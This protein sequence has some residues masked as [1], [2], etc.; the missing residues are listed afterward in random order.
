M[1]TF[2]NSEISSLISLRIKRTFLQKVRRLELRENVLLL[3]P[4][5]YQEHLFFVKKGIIRCALIRFCLDCQTTVFENEPTTTGWNPWGFNTS[6]PLGSG[7]TLGG[8]NS[9]SGGSNYTPQCNSSI[10]SGTS[11]SSNQLPPCIPITKIPDFNPDNIVYSNFEDFANDPYYQPFFEDLTEAEIQ[12]FRDHVNLIWSGARNYNEVINFGI[13]RFHNSHEDN[14]NA[15]AYRHMLWCGTNFLSWDLG[16]NTN[17]AEEFGNLHE[18]GDGTENQHAMDRANN[19]AGINL[20]R[21][22][23]SDKRNR[24]GMSEAAMNLMVQ[25]NTPCRRLFDPT[26]D[27]S[28]L[29]PTDGTGRK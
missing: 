26:D 20:A 1:F 7:S 5:R 9:V 29:I 16:N 2:S 14:S 13:A 3:S 6:L 25:P 22:L 17:F 24:A 15:N 28:P 8:G 11:V 27:N 4:G 19:A 21:N 12:F 23:P 10:P 18:L